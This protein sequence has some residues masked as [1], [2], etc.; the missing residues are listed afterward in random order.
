MD[1]PHLQFANNLLQTEVSEAIKAAIVMETDP[2]TVAAYVNFL[3]MQVDKM[4]GQIRHDV[5]FS[6]AETCATLV[7]QRSVAMTTHNEF[8][9][10]GDLTGRSWSQAS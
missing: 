10:S 4:N 7:Y 9:T 6:I 3:R 5:I 2:W 8:N 1:L